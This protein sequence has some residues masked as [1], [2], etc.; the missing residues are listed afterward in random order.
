[1]WHSKY[2]V[3]YHQLIALVDGRCTKFERRQDQ[4]NWIDCLAER[5]PSDAVGFPLGDGEGNSRSVGEIGIVFLKESHGEGLIHGVFRIHALLEVRILLAHRFAG[6]L[7]LLR[8]EVQYVL[9]ARKYPLRKSSDR[10]NNWAGSGNT[11]WILMLELQLEGR[12]SQSKCFLTSLSPH[13]G[14]KHGIINLL[15]SL[16]L[17]RSEYLSTD[18]TR[19]L[20]CEI[21]SLLSWLTVP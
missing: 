20:G 14:I 4:R 6:R 12:E 19:L 17:V 8:G 11:H 13:L 5:R 2:C 3:R 21:L 9:P 18:L 16:I 10:V 1:M 7:V 15:T